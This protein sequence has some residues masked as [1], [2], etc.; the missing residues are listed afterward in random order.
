MNLRALAA[1]CS[2]FRKKTGENRQNFADFLTF[3]MEFS[4]NFFFD[5]AKIFFE[6]LFCTQTSYQRV[7]YVG[8]N[9]H[10]K[11]E[12]NRSHQ[13][14]FIWKKRSVSLGRNDVDA[15]SRHVRLTLLFSQECLVV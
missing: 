6:D 14:E 10:V 12:V 5:R 4:S 8:G 15:S 2:I 11:Y 7:R 9:N 3:F 1:L 13:T